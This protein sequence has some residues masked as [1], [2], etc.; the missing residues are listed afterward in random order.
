MIL[1]KTV[2]ANVGIPYLTVFDFVMINDDN[3]KD[4]WESLYYIWWV[5]SAIL[6]FAFFFSKVMSIFFWVL[7]PTL[8][9]QELRST[10]WWASFFASWLELIA[11]N[12]LALHKRCLYL[13]FLWPVFSYIWTEYG[14]LLSKSPYSVQ[15]WEEVG[16]KN[17]KYGQLLC[18]I[19]QKHYLHQNKNFASKFF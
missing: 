14:D 6:L 13:E 12:L 17:S 19:S 11:S 4:I 16:H 9:L 7:P 15:T 18:I 3:D 10:C 8:Y 1:R 2:G 5:F